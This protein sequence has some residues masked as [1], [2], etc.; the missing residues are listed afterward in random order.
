MNHTTEN[1]PGRR[2]FTLKGA[3]VFLGCCILLGSCIIAN[4]NNAA[5]TNPNH[6]QLTDKIDSM[7]QKLDKVIGL[8]SEDAP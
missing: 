4:Q 1:K 6:A 7:N 5:V 2:E 3:I 8:L